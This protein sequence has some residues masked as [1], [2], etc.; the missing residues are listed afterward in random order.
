[1]GTLS[2]HTTS[3]NLSWR[4]LEV[5]SWE[6]IFHGTAKP[7]L[8]WPNPLNSL[9]ITTNCAR[10]YSSLGRH[11][12]SLLEPQTAVLTSWVDVDHPRTG[13]WHLGV[14]TFLETFNLG[15]ATVIP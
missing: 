4:K 2:V 11:L 6:R 7:P 15:I 14:G 12:C 9:K 8:T 3:E 10:R 13:G 1:M 5:E